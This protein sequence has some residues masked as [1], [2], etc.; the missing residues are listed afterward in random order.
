[1]S[2]K[3]RYYLVALFWLAFAVLPV[4]AQ[5]DHEENEF[6]I[7]GF[8]LETQPG[9]YYFPNFIENLAPD[10]V[11][12]TEESN[13]FGVLDRP[14]VY[15]E[16]DSWT[17]FQWHYAGFS[18]NSALDDGA[19]ALQPPFLAITA[20]S[21]RGE[22]AERRDYGFDF[23]PRSPERT[24][25]RLMLSTV[26]PNLGGWTSLG[27]L[28]VANHASLR[29]ADLYSTRRK[30]G[31]NT[32][33]D[34]SFEK[35]SPQRSLLLAASY[36]NLDRRFNDFNERDRQFSEDADLLQLLSRWQGR[37]GAGTLDLDLVVN[38]GGRGRL[39]AENGRY[40]QETYEQDK[41]SWLVGASWT[42][43]PC[44]LKLSWIQEWQE[45]RP[46]APDAG[47][48]LMDIDG[49]GFF[50]FEK[51]GRFQ[52][53][54]LALAADKKI[55]FSWLGRKASIEPY[56]D[57]NAV[58]HAAAER[59]GASNGIFF[60]GQPYLAV[61]WQGSR[62]YRN[63]RRSAAVGTLFNMELSERFEL[64][65]RLFGQYQGLSFHAQR[66]D[67]D[68][69]QAGGEGGF[70]LRAGKNTRVSLSYGNL[71]YEMR[72]GAIDFLED[73]RP[74]AELYLWN[75]DNRDGLVQVDEKGAFFGRSGGSSHFLSPELKPTRRES[76]ALLLTTRL[77]SHFHLD[78]KGLYKKIHRPLWVSFADAYGHYEDLG[79]QDYYLLDRPFEAFAL[80]NAAFAKEPFYA[81]FLIR[82]RG[83]K[84][85]RW[86]FSFSFLAHMGMGTTAFGN[87]PEANDIGVIS[88][89]QAFPNAW[90]NGFG[91]VDGDRAFVG[92]I[93]FGYYLSSRLFL[94]GSVKYRDGDPFAF[95][96]AFQRQ[97]QWILTYQTIKAEDEHG[98]KGGPREDC[99][100]DFNFKLGYDISLF[101]KKGRLECSV[102]NL[103]DF[104]GE[105]SE[106]AFSND[107][108]RLANELQLPRSLR[109]G[110]VL[111]L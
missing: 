48:D 74:G 87:G 60:A 62:D 69:L 92:K 34:Y 81:Q 54:T 58:F 14:K 11:W 1:M 105:L 99:I 64:H 80:G 45:L 15:F 78:I 50:P 25:S 95:I 28:A 5:S 29:A 9:G 52:A 86:Y 75:D 107:M 109:L 100:W 104:G 26:V 53:A 47:K 38:A 16:G 31:G 4:R 37:Y 32:Q 21:L 44:N 6:V 22:S 67:R 18:I 63:Q 84:A 2:V 61:L 42:G 13:G 76:L 51:W 96:N 89:S 35:K 55:S 111:E 56:L 77:S 30:I 24:V 3:R 72:A 19:P 93:F 23:T 103:L 73:Q 65:A 43:R 88:E 57:L 12:L 59:T 90:I 39:F 82:V 71:P 106:N 68:F 41:R 85:R 49:Q 7:D 36:Y 40:P 8:K 27:K 83:E 97:G 20:M 108:E 101:G 102:F 91:R 66:N 17:Q 98:K 70:A 94:G 10:A 33:F 110:I 79:G 46:V